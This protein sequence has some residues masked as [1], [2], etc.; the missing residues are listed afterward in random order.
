MHL[1]VLPEF[2]DFNT[3]VSHHGS[4]A[5]SSFQLQRATEESSAENKEL[6]KSL[7][8]AKREAWMKLIS[9]FSMFTVVNV[10][11]SSM[12]RYEICTE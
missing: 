2:W 5:R 10:E 8:K 4:M 7:E 6:H 1:A 9:F 11:T 12:L 3:P